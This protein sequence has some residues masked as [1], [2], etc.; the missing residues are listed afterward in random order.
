MIIKNIIMERGE[1]KIKLG[2]ELLWKFIIRPPK[3]IYPLH[4]LG[5]QNFRYNSKTY[6]RRDF[7]LIS[8]QG[9]K[10]KSSLI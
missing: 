3:D 2:Y 6:I 4:Y 9:Y 10:M 8:H 5:P 1:T 7:D